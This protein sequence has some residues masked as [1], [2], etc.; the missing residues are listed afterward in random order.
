MNHMPP[1]PGCGECPT[2]TR[3]G[4]ALIVACACNFAAFEIAAGD[5]PER[6][7]KIIQKIKATWEEAWRQT[8]A[9]FDAS[10]GC[11]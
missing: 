3:R 6:E 1:C 8:H 2:W 10:G 4:P 7:Q 9:A 5:T 11:A